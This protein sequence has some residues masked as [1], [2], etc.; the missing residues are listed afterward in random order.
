MERKETHMRVLYRN[1]ADYRTTGGDCGYEAHSLLHERPLYDNGG[2]AGV[3]MVEKRTMYQDQEKTT[4]VQVRVTT[5][6]HNVD[7]NQT[8]R[9]RSPYP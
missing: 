1:G 8:R 3:R 2:S 9:K 6:M 4:W 7:L 5:E